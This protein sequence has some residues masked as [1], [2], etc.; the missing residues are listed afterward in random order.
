MKMP[1]LD[2][3]ERVFRDPYIFAP[4]VK[5]I[6]FD[7]VFVNLFMLM[8]NNGARI[9][10]MLKSGTFHEIKS[11]KKYFQVLEGNHEVSGFTENPEAL[12]SW[13]R[14][15]LVNMVYRGKAKENIT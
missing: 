11:L 1:I 2:K 13:L 10:L 8:R 5:A 6:T 9:K 3:D 4:D 7:N 12:E 15:S 14:S